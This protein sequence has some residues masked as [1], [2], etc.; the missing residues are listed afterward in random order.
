MEFQQKVFSL[1]EATGLNWSVNK[2][3]LFS[4]DGKAANR[5][6]MFRNDNNA[7]LGV[8]GERYTV[9]QNSQLAETMVQASEGVGINLEK[10]GLLGGGGK[11]YLQA[12]LQPEFIGKSSVKRYITALNSHDGSTSIGFGSSSTVVVCQNT[13]FR[14]Y[15]EV[16][17]IRHTVTAESRVKE[18]MEQLRNAL[19]LDN[20]LMETFKRM[21]DMEMKDELV[22]RVI[23]KIFSVDPKQTQQEEIS[24]RKKNQISEFAGAITKEIELE[25]KT[26]WGLFNA[27]TRY[28]NHHKA[29]KDEAKRADYLMDGGGY[30]INNM[31]Y[32][33]IMVWLDKNTAELVEVR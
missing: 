22:E 5:F 3:P 26:V 19:T 12:E 1:L 8:V 17:K 7:C 32:E 6:G 9:F 4:Q 27:V 29:P 15:G 2:E 30:Q 28:T 33:E 14:A 31:C 11:V 16:T 25:G 24:S 21:A 13:F 23:R 20:K 18:A 10:G